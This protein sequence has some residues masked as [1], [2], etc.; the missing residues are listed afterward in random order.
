MNV[1]AFLGTIQCRIGIAHR[2]G[3]PTAE[4]VSSASRAGDTRASEILQTGGEALGAA[5]AFS[6]NLLDPEAVILGGG[7]GLNDREFRHALETSMRRHIW[8]EETRGH[9]L[10]DA[11]LG[12]QAGVVGAARAALNHIPMTTAC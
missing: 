12:E 3:A 9:F 4:D 2:F 11:K 8:L 5:I 6:V 1:A 10:L 7:V